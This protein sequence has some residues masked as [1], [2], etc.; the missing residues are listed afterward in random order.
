MARHS[1]AAPHEMRFRWYRL[2]EED[3]KTIKETC[4]IFSISPKTYHK[5]WKK[6]HGLG[7]K[8]YK[9]KAEH[10]QTKIKG[11][12]RILLVEAKQTY[13]Y[14]PKKMQ[15]YLKEKTGVEVST[16]AIYYFMRK[17]HLIRKPQKK[18]LWYTPMKKPYKA[19]KAGE[20]VQLDVKYVPAVDGGWD[21]Q[22]RF[23]DT[24]SNL[25]YSID[26]PLRLKM[27]VPLSVPFTE[28]SDRSHSSLMASRRTMAVS[29][30]VC[31]TNTCSNET[32][33]SDTFLNALL[34][35]TG[36]WR[37]QTAAWTTSSI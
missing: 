31:S 22:F 18:Q 36:R 6:D 14:G 26:L 4:R 10:P 17:K 21:Y 24:V 16:T 8:Q 28:P 35:G 9:N 12:V 3:G 33:L 25:Q 13:N 20:N 1:P 27:L 30:E 34:P 37:E 11:R 2:V 5:W 15:I 29:L 32:S 7:P 19:S 23:I